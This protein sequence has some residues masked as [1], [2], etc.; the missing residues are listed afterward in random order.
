MIDI[1]QRCIDRLKAANIAQHAAVEPILSHP[2]FHTRNILVAAEDHGRIT[3][4][5]E[6]AFLLAATTPDFAV[7]PPTTGYEALL[8]KEQ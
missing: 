5:I 1:F 4:V 8:T 3:G 6:P 7:D 2:D